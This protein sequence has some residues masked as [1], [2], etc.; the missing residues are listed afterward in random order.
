MLDDVSDLYLA[1]NPHI[2][3]SHPSSYSENVGSNNKEFRTFVL[4]SSLIDAYVIL[5]DF[6][7]WY[8][9]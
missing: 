2:I 5:N 9:T 7:K 6:I 3:N 1:E 4:S 8:L